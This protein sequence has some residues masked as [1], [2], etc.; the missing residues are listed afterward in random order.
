M[1][2][3]VFLTL[4]I[5][6]SSHSSSDELYIDK[7]AKIPQSDLDLLEFP[8]NLEY[9]EAE[10]FLY[11]ALGYGLDKAAPKL[12][13]GGPTPLGAKKANLDPF[14]RDV[15]LQ[16]AYQE[17]GHLRFFSF[18]LSQIFQLLKI[19]NLS[20]KEIIIFISWILIIYADDDNVCILQ[21]Y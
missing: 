9:F 10:F 20:Y 17:V 4:L 2:I 3:L 7:S 18:S 6:P 16:F 19:S 1:C 14:T 5:L 13:G 12:T 15:V 8:L 21:G 11:G